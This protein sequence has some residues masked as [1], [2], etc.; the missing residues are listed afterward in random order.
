VTPGRATT[1]ALAAGALLAAC[2]GSGGSASPPPPSV[3]CGVSTVGGM[4]VRRFCGTGTV[5]I[6][7]GSKATSLG[8]AECVVAQNRVTV[9][10]GDLVLGRASGPTRALAYVGLD[11]TGV[12]PAPGAPSG[13]PSYRGLISA[14]LRGQVV[15][16]TDAAVSLTGPGAA[17]AGRG[18]AGDGSTVVVSFSCVG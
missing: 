6:M 7:V 12:P 9:N 11:V 10:A 18:R 4:S 8:G 1:S 2:S 13:Q 15:S 16:V 17:G 5:T 14:D 3:P